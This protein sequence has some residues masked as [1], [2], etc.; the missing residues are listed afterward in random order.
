MP[1]MRKLI[2]FASML[3]LV[4]SGSFAAVVALPGSYGGV[5]LNIF[6]PG[7]FVDT[8]NQVVITRNFSD[9]GP[10]ALAYEIKL[11]KLV[12]GQTFGSDPNGYLLAETTGRFGGGLGL[13]RNPFASS[14]VELQSNIT[15][16]SVRAES[17]FTYFFRVT[18][19]ES[20]TRIR[21]TSFVY[22]ADDGF[23]LSIGGGTLS[24]GYAGRSD[25][26]FEE[27][28]LS[29]AIRNSAC[30]VQNFNENIDFLTVRTNEIIQVSMNSYASSSS[31]RYGAFFGDPPI[32]SDARLSANYY[33]D[34]FFEIDPN[35]AGASLYSFEFSPG[36]T[37]NP[38]SAVPDVSSWVSLMLGFSIVGLIA[39]RRSGRFARKIA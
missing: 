4:E 2:V 23:E 20:T 15:L 36:V 37:N 18:G 6:A 19:P 8:G 29:K 31:H 39:R 30:L 11:N 22:G 13:S 26:L 10:T 12:N 3:W 27:C 5:S 25:K 21:M 35:F 17:N 1:V 38:I 7:N 14:L 32:Q 34:P 33:V 24:L 16:T 28:Y 9:Q